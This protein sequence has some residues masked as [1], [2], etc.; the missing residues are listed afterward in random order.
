[1]AARRPAPWLKPLAHVLLSLP[2]AWLLYKWALIALFHQFEALGADP[3]QYT[4]RF[5]GDWALRALIAALGVTPLTRISGWKP[6]ARIRRLTGLWAFT[7]VLLH[8]MT[9]FGMD[10]LFSLSLLWE[11]V[12]KRVFITVGM[13]AFLMLIPLAATSTRGMIRRLGARNWQR[14]HKLVYIVGPLGVLHYYMMIRGNQLSP[15]IHGGVLA[16]FLGYRV[17]DRLRFKYRKAQMQRAAQ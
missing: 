11:D 6:L 17:F 7:Y 16:F 3:V 9:Y 1:M 2:L 14:L 12:V 15:W 4:I 10:R 5:S 8:L 13:A